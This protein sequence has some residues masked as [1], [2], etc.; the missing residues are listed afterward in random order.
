MTYLVF[1]PKKLISFAAII[2]LLLNQKSLWAQ[3]ETLVKG[4]VNEVNGLPVS[5]AS[6]IAT[7]QKTI[8]HL[9]P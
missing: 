6:V 1:K 3:S 2:L 4:Q 5:G 9:G 7:N 8:S